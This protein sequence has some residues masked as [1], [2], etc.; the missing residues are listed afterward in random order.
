M[1]ARIRPVH[2]AGAIAAF[3]EAATAAVPVILFLVLLQVPPSQPVTAAV[4]AVADALRR[5][6]QSTVLLQLQ[7]YRGYRADAVRLSAAPVTE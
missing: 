3:T 2:D 5:I 7:T 4:S 6:A 1:T